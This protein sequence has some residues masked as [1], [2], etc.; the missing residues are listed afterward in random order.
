MQRHNL[1]VAL[2]WLCL[3][4]A[5]IAVASC[6]GTE[7]VGTRAREAA[8][9][10]RANPEDSVALDN[11]VATLAEIPPGS[12]HY[13]VEGDILLTRN[14]IPGFLRA[15]QEGPSPRE[16]EL[17]VNVVNGRLDYLAT[18]QS[19]RLTYLVDTAS[20]RSMSEANLTRAA[21]QVATRDWVNACPECGISFTE[22]APADVTAGR[23]RPSFVVRYRHL[24]NGPIARAFFPT[25]ADDD[26][27]LEVFPDFFSPNMGFDRAG[28]IRHEVGHILGYRHEHILGVPGCYLE[29]ANW[30]QLGPYTPNSVMHYFCG[31]GGSFDMTLRV[32]DVAQHRCLYLTGRPCAR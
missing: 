22:V 14:Q 24:A 18:P 32:N 20:F 3:G 6:G 7:S 28:V 9:A 31:G 23:M 1:K 30:R 2:A 27:F 17:I 12:G 4:V 5:T 13:L 10:I 26:H 19:R 25:W 16:K 15:L 21:M 8:A 29:D 11:Y